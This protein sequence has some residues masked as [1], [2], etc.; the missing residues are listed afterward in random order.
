MGEPSKM[1]W[2]VPIKYS[3]PKTI[4]ELRKI[5]T[6]AMC[7]RIEAAALLVAWGFW[8]LAAHYAPGLEVNWTRITLAALL[9]WPGILLYFLIAALVPDCVHFNKNH[10]VI[11]IG[12][13]R[14]Q[15]YPYNEISNVSL[16]Q[17]TNW[18]IL[19]FKHKEKEIETA[20]SAKVSASRL[21]DVLSRHGVALLAGRQN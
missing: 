8:A 13:H 5:I 20:L 7:A 10:I 14:V 16:I 11:Q 2:F 19:R 12:G 17:E 3:F 18:R 15:F 6:F 9:I 1:S 21:A 4:S